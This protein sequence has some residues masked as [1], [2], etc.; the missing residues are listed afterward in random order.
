MQTIWASIRSAALGFAITV[1]TP[2]A[3][4]GAPAFSVQDI[5][6][7]VPIDVNSSGQIL[8]LD[9]YSATQPWVLDGTTKSFLPLPAGVTAAT[10][11][12]IGE[13][14]AVVGQVGK[15]AAVW[16]PA[17]AG[18]RTLDL[19]AFPTGA[20]VGKAV[21]V[22]KL[23]QVL[24]SFGTP[25]TLVTGL[26]VWSYKP[27]LYTRGGALVDLSAIY[28][29]ITTFADPMDLT[30]SGRVLL[31]SGQILEPNGSVVT[32]TPAFPEPPPGGYHW[33]FFRATRLNEAGSFIGV[34]TLSSSMGYAQVVRYTPRE[35]WKVLGG[36]SANVMA[37]GI[38]RAGD[39]LFLANYV[40]P[41][42]YGLAF[43]A[44]NVGTYCLDD[45]ILGGGWSFLSFSSRG[46]L[47]P[48]SPNSNGVPASNP[49]GMMA[50][51]GYSTAAGSYRLARL[52]PAGDLPKPPA[53]TLAATPHPGTWQQP[54][55]SITLTW[56]SG[57]YL[58]KAYAIER[59]DPGSSNFAEIARIGATVT[60]YEDQNIT[61]MATYAY[62][63]AA[64]GLAGAGAYS[65]E[66][67][68]KAPAPMDRTSPLVTIN[69]PADGATVTGT[70]SVSATFTDNVG[71]VYADLRF[72]PSMGSEVI[73]SRSLTAA[74]TSL[75][76]SCKW[77]TRKVAYQSPTAT[78][79]AYGY[80]AIG[81]WVQASV[82]VNVTYSTKGRGK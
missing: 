36:L 11:T 41:I 46:A 9:T 5:G 1:L 47:A 71:L 4:L 61:P 26:V 63:V 62:R 79:T 53:V 24:V 35:G 20:T 21:A 43:N 8:G 67:T 32:A 76:V 70:V 23:D 50:A 12:R 73:C 74:T 82:N 78:V 59:K 51:L 75:T 56:T 55:D 66:A 25:S 7:G 68:A 27:Y 17:G 31:Q 81:N 69:A 10:A 44:I 34:A 3:A 52:M 45:L 18:S 29:S 48:T 58:A 38:D 65:N 15:Q 30:D 14:G 77:D 22:N 54:Y 13:S 80:D 64:I 2:L 28:T 60:Q 42:N 16:W 49:V 19:L 40:C 57:G 72:S 33:V 6:V 37:L 39:A